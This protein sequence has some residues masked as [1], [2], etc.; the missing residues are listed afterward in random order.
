MTLL[1]LCT[2]R[3]QGSRRLDTVA[4]SVVQ[5]LCLGDSERISFD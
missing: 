5:K 1:A 3:L 4:L 2:R